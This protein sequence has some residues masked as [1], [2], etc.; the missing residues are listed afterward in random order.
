MEMRRTLQRAHVRS[1]SPREVGWHV[2]NLVD[3]VSIA[4]TQDP[5][6]HHLDAIVSKCYGML[7]GV[8]TRETGIFIYLSA[9]A[10]W[11]ISSLSPSPR[12]VLMDAWT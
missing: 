7:A 5:L 6:S 1:M 12:S 9:L 2:S 8:L 11:W 4:E 10:N 3:E